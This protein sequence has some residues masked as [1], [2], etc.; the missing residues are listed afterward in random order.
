MIDLDLYKIFIAVAEETSITKA[1][2]KLFISQPAVTK[3][4][5]SL[6][7]K[8]GGKLFLRM[9]NGVTLTEDGQKLYKLAKEPIQN[10]L[11]IEDDLSEIKT[12]NLSAHINMFE[13]ISDILVNFK[14]KHKNISVNVQGTELQNMVTSD[15]SEMLTSLENQKYDLVISK[16]TDNLNK[17]KIEFI[18][19]G[20]IQDILVCN[21]N[22]N[23]AK[24]IIGKE[25][26]KHANLLLPKKTSVTTINFFN[27]LNLR[28][29]EFEKLNFIAYKL[30]PKLI[31]ENDY[32]GLASENY[33]CHELKSGQLSK[34]QTEFKIPP[35]DFGIYVNKSNIT[36]ELKLLVNTLKKAYVTP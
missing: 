33:I 17:N 6:E 10:L 2:E 36:N 24:R 4:I 18:K 12:I 15:L 20:E 28:E 14:N 25:T 22:S 19:L 21:P 16:K 1:S 13:M 27:S 35:I 23:Y 31:K 30:M 7:D 3:Q 34:V 29:E 26:L 9:N 8:L 32:I 5:K 11:K